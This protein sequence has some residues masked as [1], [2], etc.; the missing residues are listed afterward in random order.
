MKKFPSPQKQLEV[1][2][3]NSSD[4]ISIDEFLKKLTRSFETGKPLRVK[5]GFDPTAPD[6]H[7]GHTVLIQKLKEFQD[8]GHHVLLLIGD[9]TGMIGDPTGRNETRK[10]LTREEVLKNADTYKEQVFK[11]LDKTKTEVVFN[12]EWMDKVSSVEL[13][14]IAAKF[15]VARMLERDDFTKRYREGRPIAIHEFLYPLVQGYDSVVLKSDVELGGTDQLF[16]LLVGR[17]LQ[18][19]SGQEPQVILTMPILEGTDGDRKMSKSFGNYIGITEPAKEIFGKVMSISDELMLRYYSLLSG[20]SLERIEDI[21]KGAVHPKEAKEALAF[22]LTLRFHGETEA[23]KAKEGF[24]NLFVKKE[25]PDD[26][27]E[28]VV[29]AEGEKMWLPKVMVEAGAVKST[30][31]A[32]RLI[33]QGG[34]KI[35]GDK[36]TDKK[37]EVSTKE[38]LLIQAGKRVFKKVVFLR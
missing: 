3:R 17:T 14:G 2:K 20:A 9:F 5:A 30:S 26:V 31:E 13:I 33:E 38:P 32:Q 1:I 12:S 36:V 8:L 29:K 35:N 6:L 21:K 27:E 34:V 16:N 37:T 11:I 7:L 24:K 18:K 10:P 28:A 22:E 4:I 25:T 23:E 19:E 15:T